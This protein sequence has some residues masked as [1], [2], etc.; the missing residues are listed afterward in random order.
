MLKVKR[1]YEAPEA[2]DGIRILVD[3]LWPRGIT[4]EQAAITQW[5]KEIAPS[6]DL[7]WWFAHRP[8]R[9]AEFKK[10]YI[11]ELAAPEKAEILSGIARLGAKSDITLLYAARDIKRNEA[12]VLEEIITRML[13]EIK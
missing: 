3:K 6:D 5:I 2:N 9:W 11:A 8:E 13:K 4:T 7:R 1:V 12:R 10:K